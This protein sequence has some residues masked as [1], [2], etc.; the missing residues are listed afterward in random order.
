MHTHIYIEVHLYL[1]T[2]CLQKKTQQLPSQ[3]LW[4]RTIATTKPPIGLNSVL[5]C[6]AVFCSVLQCIENDF[7]LGLSH[8]LC[9]HHQSHP[10][11]CWRVLKCVGLCCS[12]LQCVGVCWIVLQCV[13]VCC[14]CSVLKIIL[15]LGPSQP[16]H[17]HHK[18]HLTV[19]VG[20]AEVVL[21]YIYTFIY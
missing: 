17:Q 6:V 19:R 21:L 15:Y 9:P 7:D 20:D 3:I 14:S 13:G 8:P 2:S 1:W 4:P 18:A 10:A 11:V 5:Q 12:V 16:L